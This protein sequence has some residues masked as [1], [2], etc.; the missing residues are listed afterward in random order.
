M[1]TYYYGHGDIFDVAAA[2]AFHIAQAQAFLDG[3]KRAGVSA[4]LGFL[5]INKV[6]VL[7][8]DLERITWSWRSRSGDATR[9]NS[10][11]SCESIGPSETLSLRLEMLQVARV[12]PRVLG[13]GADLVRG[14]LCAAVWARRGRAA[15]ATGGRIFITR[16]SP[17]RVCRRC[18]W[19]CQAEPIEEYLLT[20]REGDGLDFVHLGALARCWAAIGL[21]RMPAGL[22]G[23]FAR[24]NRGASHAAMA[25]TKRTK[26]GRREMPTGAS[27]RSAP[28]RTSAARCRNRCAWCSA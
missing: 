13:D 26:E 9:F 14:F 8:D 23:D 5:D 15:T 2:Y 6:R 7:T 16:S 17:S 12:A 10:L 19:S 24:E 4:A 25:G 1:N 3:N 28:T 20:F 22:R 21:E 27:W 11:R 18:R